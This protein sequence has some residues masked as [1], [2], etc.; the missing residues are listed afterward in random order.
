M[1]IVYL[2]AVRSMMKGMEERAGRKC[3]ATEEV[4]CGVIQTPWG[5]ARTA[6]LTDDAMPRCVGMVLSLSRDV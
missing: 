1:R 5:G 4:S 3:G 6:A 2:T